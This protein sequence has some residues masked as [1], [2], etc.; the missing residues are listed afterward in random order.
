MITIRLPEPF[1]IV[2]EEG[3]DIPDND[4]Y[5]KYTNIEKEVKVMVKSFYDPKIEE[6]GRKEGRKEEKEEKKKRKKQ[7]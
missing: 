1:V 6:K 5:G 3:T 2:L 7:D 4:I